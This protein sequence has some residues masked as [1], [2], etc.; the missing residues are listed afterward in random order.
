MSIRV[1][2]GWNEWNGVMNHWL[3]VERNL[4]VGQK[5]PKISENLHKVKVAWKQDKSLPVECIWNYPRSTFGQMTTKIAASGKCCFLLLLTLRTRRLLRR[6]CGCRPGG[7][8]Q[9]HETG[10]VNPPHTRDLVKEMMDGWRTGDDDFDE[11]LP[12]PPH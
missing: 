4:V 12:L 10:G 2:G 6:E 7:V 1:D 11:L 8:D 5:E 9:Y 3:V